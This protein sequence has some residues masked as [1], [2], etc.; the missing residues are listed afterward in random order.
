MRRFGRNVIL[1]LFEVD[2]SMRLPFS[3]I[4]R[5]TIVLDPFYKR[6]C[7][8]FGELASVMDHLHRVRDFEFDLL[9]G[10]T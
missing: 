7:F 5:R 3:L 9:Y 10:Q 8:V 6:S 2:F 4:G 1:Q